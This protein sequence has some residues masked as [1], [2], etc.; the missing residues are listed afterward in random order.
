MKQYTRVLSL[1]RP[2]LRWT[3]IAGLL[4]VMALT[5]TL[6][7]KKQMAEREMQQQATLQSE[8]SRHDQLLE[9][10]TNVKQHIQRYKD[11]QGQGLIG[12]TSRAN[13]LERLGE[14]AREQGLYA[15][16]KATLEA[17][18][19]LAVQGAGIEGEGKAIGFDLNFELSPVMETDVLEL[20]DHYRATAHGRFRLQQCTWVE[21]KELGFLARC[22]LRFFALVVDQITPGEATQ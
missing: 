22:K 9:D 15:G 7:A 17:P 14:Q 19:P 20:V 11:L 10:L 5:V 16:F 21:P 8:Q 13:W 2:T 12:D 6:W 3:G 18:Q 1:L 4:F